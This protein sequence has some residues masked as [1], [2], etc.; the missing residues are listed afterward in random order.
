M[1]GLTLPRIDGASNEHSYHSSSAVR[2][3]DASPKSVL[4]Q[5]LDNLQTFPFP[6]I[7]AEASVKARL[8]TLEA[9]AAAQ[10]EYN[11]QEGNALSSLSRNLDD[12]DTNIKTLI[13]NMQSDFDMRILAMKKEYDHRF[14]S[15]PSHCVKPTSDNSIITPL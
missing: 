13:L 2:K 15:L 9:T 7:D 11:K 10:D 3:S 4:Q 6:V 14:A 5:R 12:V 8:I 1:D